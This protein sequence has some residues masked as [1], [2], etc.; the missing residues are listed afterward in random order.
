[1]IL[2]VGSDLNN[3]SLYQLHKLK[4]RK[5]D[6]RGGS[7]DGE[8]TGGPGEDPGGDSSKNILLTETSGSEES[9]P[10]TNVDSPESTGGKP[11]DEPLPPPPP[12]Q[13]RASPDDG[14][15]GLQQPSTS[16]IEDTKSTT[17][18]DPG[19]V[20]SDEYPMERSS[21]VRSSG[22][23]GMKDGSEEV[24]SD[25]SDDRVSTSGANTTIPSTMKDSS[26]FNIDIGTD[27]PLT[28]VTTSRGDS[29]MTS[30][31]DVGTRPASPS[32]RPASVTFSS[33]SSASKQI[34]HRRYSA[35]AQPNIFVDTSEQYWKQQQIRRQMKLS[36]SVDPKKSSPPSLSSPPSSSSVI[37][38]RNPHPLVSRSLQSKHSSVAPLHTMY[39][40][41]PNMVRTT[42]I[43]PT[44]TSS[45]SGRGALT[46]S[47]NVSGRGTSTVTVGGSGT[48]I[49]STRTTV[50]IPH[51][52]TEN[53]LYRSVKPTSPRVTSAVFPTVTTSGANVPL[54]PQQT[55]QVSPP[56]LSSPSTVKY[57]GSQYSEGSPLN[58]RS[59]SSSSDSLER[60]LSSGSIPPHS[61]V[62]KTAQYQTTLAA[63]LAS[64][65]AAVTPARYVVSTDRPEVWS[66]SRP[67]VTSSGALLPVQQQAD[68]PQALN[69]SMP[70]WSRQNGK[71]RSGSSSA[72]MLPSSSSTL[73]APSTSRV[74]DDD[75]DHPM[76]CMICDDKATGLHYGIIT[77]EGCKGFFKRTVQNK[78][79][80][81]CVADGNC[82]ITKAQR[83][84]CQY[85]RFQK[86]LRQGMVLAAVR[87]DRMP[88]GR[89]SGAVYNL[90][91][92]KYKKHK[93]SQKNG[94][95]RQ[96]EQQK[97]RVYQMD[98]ELVMSNGQILKTAL[99][100]PS[101]VSHLRHRGDGAVVSSS[102]D[103]QMPIDQAMSVI[104][105][106]IECDDFEEIA[107]LQNIQD[108]LDNFSDLSQKLCQIGDNIVYRLVQWTKRLPFYAELP[109]A[110]HTQMLT[111][112]WHE[113]L[114]LTTSAYQ[115]IHGGVST[116]LSGH[117]AAV[118]AGSGD[119]ASI[120]FQQEVSTNLCTLQT[121]LSSMMGR[122]ITMDQLRQEVGLMV[123]KITHVTSVF[124]KLK[125][126]ME[127]YV[128][129]KVIDMLSQ[130]DTK[131]HQELEQIRERYLASLRSFV[132]NRY[133]HQPTRFHD[134]LLCLPEVQSAAALLLQS[135]MFYVPFL[136]NSTIV[137]R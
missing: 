7:S 37:I 81:T 126:C 56:V 117:P 66:T 97:P 104:N 16:G 131:T 134:L 77:C 125:L 68:S 67:Q 1:M 114:V 32:T 29:F 74:G 48:A 130:E 73:V 42:E 82:E 58:K 20:F 64:T 22:D 26:V 83:N 108:L 36:E 118:L 132:D 41:G 14:T 95:V 103:R 71:N 12:P 115:S 112:K 135:K 53:V 18:S 110:V 127:E 19:A 76:I 136:L 55:T 133:P 46:T 33:P 75:E 8:G 91:K 121:C 5:I 119:S 9:S 113:L 65:S 137:S 107:T 105:Q 70:S 69:L 62:E 78:R 99:T 13:G 17:E 57:Y 51:Q 40:L 94:Q 44:V 6:S 85:C 92:V 93:K 50:E 128:C 15:A 59:F 123:E 30:S 72:L 89:N 96:G 43:I 101:E 109:V 111:H 45:L 39:W 102:R 10:K 122:P 27:E 3:M 88:G 4:R 87:E 24:P 60:Q 106:L 129:L 80:Y 38:S 120:E 52:M 63:A 23:R 98:Q 124:R 61:P 90:Y 49:S 100:N 25:R 54:S 86:C 28:I 79:V 31:Y 2:K 11:V 35:G 34:D 47:A 21:P 84:R 116:S